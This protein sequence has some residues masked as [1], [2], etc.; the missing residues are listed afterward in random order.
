MFLLL[1]LYGHHGNA[2]LVAREIIWNV[3]HKAVSISYWYAPNKLSMGVLHTW[4]WQSVL[5]NY[6]HIAHTLIKV[7]EN[8]E[9]FYSHLGKYKA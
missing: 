8:M 9:P 1:L 2:L 4:V 6:D 5:P 7:K 3:W